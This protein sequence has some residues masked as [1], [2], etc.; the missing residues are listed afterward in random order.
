MAL[1]IDGR[2]LQPP[3]PFERTMEALD[4]LPPG[5]EL[6]LLLYVTPTPLF[7]ALRRNNYVWQDNIQADG[8]HEIR[9]RQAGK[10]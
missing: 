2:G 3:E 9:I 6:T 4:T 5:E 10:S 8:T 7:N 1:I